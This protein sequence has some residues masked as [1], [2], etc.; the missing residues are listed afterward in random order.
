MPKLATKYQLML[1]AAWVLAVFYQTQFAE[2]SFVDDLDALNGILTQEHFSWR[3]AFLPHAIDGGYYRPLIAVSYWLD[4]TL[5]FLAP[6]NMHFESVAGHLINCV[7][8]YF[9]ARKAMHLYLNTREG[10]LPLAVSMLFSVHPIVTESVNWISGRTDIMMST[11][12]L[13]SLLG[14]L[15]FRTDRSRQSLLFALLSAAVALLAKEAALG[16]IVGL[17]LLMLPPERSG[18]AIDQEDGVSSSKIIPFLL[19]FTLMVV[20]AIHTGRYWLVLMIAGAYLAYLIRVD[21]PRHA[22]F[23]KH[24]AVMRLFVLFP[25]FIGSILGFIAIRKTVFISS[26]GK[27][28]QTVILM[29]ADT[30]YTI[31]LFLGALGFYV[32][33]F[34]APLPLNFYIHEIDPLFDL[35]GILVL[36]LIVLLMTVNK[37]PATLAL[38]GFMTLVPALPFAFG[39]IA[40]TSYAERYIYLPCSIWLLAFGLCVG[41]WLQKYPNHITH[42]IPVTVILC[43]ITGYITFSRNSVWKTNVALMKDTVAQTPK[44]RVLHDIYIRSLLSAG[45][46]QE[47]EQQYRYASV[48]VPAGDDDVSDLAL[49]QYLVC[50]KRYGEALQ[51]YRQA[52]IRTRFSS[53]KLLSAAIGVLQ[54]L[55]QEQNTSPG[56]KMRLMSLENEYLKKRAAVPDNPGLWSVGDKGMTQT[57]SYKATNGRF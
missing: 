32:K 11:F 26:V 45:M 2:I 40:W 8:L 4:K 51:L 27:I 37:L 47:A 14:V 7:L 44:K 35:F 48:I 22:S 52:I 12:A 28:G 49:G 21:L 46:T 18:V 6:R 36:L 53:K 57:G 29:L 16:Y 15:H 30:N 54:K 56:E 50:Q 20:T 5:W 17:P 33:K 34:F 1:L 38:L 55:R 19:T 31:S 10:Y 39:T 13:I 9:A 41:R 25:S 23:I 3:E 24:I 42:F 43:T